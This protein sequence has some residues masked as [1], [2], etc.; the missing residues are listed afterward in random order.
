[1]EL[2]PFVAL[3]TPLAVKRLYEVFNVTCVM[4]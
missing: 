2:Q 4:R 3:A 1:M